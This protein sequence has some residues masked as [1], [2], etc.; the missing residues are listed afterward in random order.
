VS[1]LVIRTKALERG[2]GF[3]WGQSNFRLTNTPFRS[4]FKSPLGTPPGSVH[5]GPSQIHWGMKRTQWG[6]QACGGG[7]SGSGTAGVGRPEASFIGLAPVD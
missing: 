2:V 5:K 6:V 7:P 1:K 4:G 3:L